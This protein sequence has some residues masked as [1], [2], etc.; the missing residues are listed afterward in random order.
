MFTINNQMK[1]ASHA[2][3]QQV[4]VLGFAINLSINGWDHWLQSVRGSSIQ[5]FP[6]GYVMNCWTCTYS[7]MC[8]LEWTW[9]NYFKLLLTNLK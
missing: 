8:I 5:F 3:I 1:C 4:Q 2:P 7:N 6:W 9:A